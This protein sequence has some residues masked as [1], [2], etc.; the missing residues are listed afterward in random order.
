MVVTSVCS[1]EVLTEG[2]VVGRPIGVMD[3]ALGVVGGITLI[4]VVGTAVVVG[5]DV[6]VGGGC[7]VA[8]VVVVAVG[9]VGGGGVSFL[10]GVGVVGVGG[11][12]L[13]MRKHK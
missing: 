8:I 6:F 2:E 10:L 7:V 1:V 5:A 12:N 3:S 13:T 11:L 4:V 9:T